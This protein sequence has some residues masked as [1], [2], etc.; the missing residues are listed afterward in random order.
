MS[1]QNLDKLKNNKG[2]ISQ[3]KVPVTQSSFPSSEVVL[4]GRFY[5]ERY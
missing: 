3:I 4:S 2:N 5:F 1:Q